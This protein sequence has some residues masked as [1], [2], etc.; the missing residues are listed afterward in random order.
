MEMVSHRKMTCEKP[1]CG[2][3][4]SSSYNEELFS[5][6]LVRF[7]YEKLSVLVSGVNGPDLA[8]L[9]SFVRVCTAGPKN[10]FHDSSLAIR[11]A[12]LFPSWPL[13]PS[14]QISVTLF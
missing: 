12:S 1:H 14:T 5:Y 10:E 8:F 6:F 13:C 11:S 3:E 9:Y 7:F 4:L 2:F